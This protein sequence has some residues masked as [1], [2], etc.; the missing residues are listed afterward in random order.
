MTSLIFGS[1][2]TPTQSAWCHLVYDQD[3][4]VVKMVT[5][6]VAP[7]SAQHETVFIFATDA[8]ILRG[9]IRRICFFQ[10]LEEGSAHRWLQHPFLWQQHFMWA[11][12]LSLC[13][14]MSVAVV[15]VADRIT[16]TATTA[17]FV[18]EVLRC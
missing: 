4:H 14:S 10:Y 17:A 3:Y 7:V 1:A 15:S 12:A 2:E 18:H 13:R 16:A 5:A 9:T 11:Q 8:H 6:P